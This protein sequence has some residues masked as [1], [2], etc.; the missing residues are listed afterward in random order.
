MA[1]TG[2]AVSVRFSRHPGL[3]PDARL[4][5]LRAWCT[6]SADY[7]D[8]CGLLPTDDEALAETRG[9][10]VTLPQFLAAPVEQR[11]FHLQSTRSWSYRF[12]QATLDAS[13]PFG[14]DELQGL[15]QLC[16]QASG[17]PVQMIRLFGRRY[18][19]GHFVG[20]HHE[21]RLG[22]ALSAHLFLTPDWSAADGGSLW[23]EGAGGDRHVLVPADN[24]MVLFD[25]AS[26]TAQGVDPVRSG[27]VLHSFQFWCYL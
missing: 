15:L 16:E 7:D 23:L 1:D 3:L 24:E 21:D 4:R 20:S 2:T 18:G 11:Y 26:V 9:Q 22:R 27:A 10:R 17:Q 19:N 5:Q 14:I 8:V 6:E 13:C 12:G 25:I